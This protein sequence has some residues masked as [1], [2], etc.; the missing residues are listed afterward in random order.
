ML[1]FVKWQQSATWPN[2]SP[3]GVTLHWAVSLGV[4]EERGLSSSWS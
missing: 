2:V 3:A 1:S 4:E